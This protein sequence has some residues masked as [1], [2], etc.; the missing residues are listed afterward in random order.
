MTTNTQPLATDPL[1]APDSLIV[2]E[3]IAW[4]VKL[5]SGLANTEDFTHCEQWRL[6]NPLHEQAWQQLQSLSGNLKAIPSSLAHA[7]LH[8]SPANH[9]LQSRRMALKSIL[10]LAGTGA[11]T[12][13]GYQ[14]APW[15]QAL[16]DYGT[17]VGEQRKIML[18]DGTAVMLNTDTAV[19]IYF[20]EN[21]RLIEL[22][23]GE[24]LITT[25]HQK[26]DNR[27]FSINTAQGNIRALGTR[28]LVLQQK[29]STLVAV[30]ES[31]VEAR[32]KSALSP[33]RVEANQQ[34]T[35]TNTQ[36]SAPT[37]AN[38]DLAA[39]TDG[40]IVAKNTRLADFT[41]ELDRY[42]TG[43][44]MC[45]SQ[46]AELLISGVFPI[47]DTDRVLE[48]L[49]RTLPIKAETHMRYWT[50]LKSIEN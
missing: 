16:A 22:L 17:S 26:D 14:F 33:T 18:A 15:Q 39:W 20:D 42:R 32:P 1:L 31:A 29:N 28:F 38:V 34:L 5:Q 4:M 25:G 13:S 3:A 49:Q 47:S 48:T 36:T 10:L 41:N 30:Y 44:I 35:F 24:V 50:T 6:S 43:I 40:V 19:N 8:Q 11:L 7:A 12:Y 27:P 9:A 21:Q 37:P 45:D 2:Q 23:K 46:A